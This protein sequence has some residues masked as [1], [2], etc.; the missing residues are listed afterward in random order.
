MCLTE[1][2]NNYVSMGCHPDSTGSATECIQGIAYL[3]FLVWAILWK[4]GFPF[5]G[6]GTQRT[7]NLLTFNNTWWEMQ[8]NIA[9][10]IP[11]GFYLSAAKEELKL[12]K[13]I[14][15]AFLFSLALEVMQFILAIGRSDITDLLMNTLGGFIGIAALYVCSKLFGNYRRQAA[16]VTC[17]MLTLLEVYMAVS[18]ILF[19]QLNLGYMIIR[20]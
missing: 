18:F 14:M 6:D 9:V 16:L 7:I 3:L 12:M 8:F 5:I 2:D 19:G 4:C 1:T 20:L 13:Q 17:V 10:F 11:F 15:K